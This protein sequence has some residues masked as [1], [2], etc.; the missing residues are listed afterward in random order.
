MPRQKS[1][2]TVIRELVRKEISRAIQS[3]LGGV[4]AGT[5]RRGRGRRGPGRPRGSKTRRR[6]GRPAKATK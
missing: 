1:L 2:V 3:L 6:R 5:S 4:A